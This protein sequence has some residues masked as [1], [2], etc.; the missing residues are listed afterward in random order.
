MMVV[1]MVLAAPLGLPPFYVNLSGQVL[2]YAIL[3]LSLDLLAGVLGLWS[4][5]HAAAFGVAAYTAAFLAERLGVSWG[6][7]LISGLGVAAAL[8]CVGGLVVMRVRGLY[9]MMLTLG[10]AQVLWALAENWTGLTGG[11]DGIPG[12]GRPSPFITTNSFYV[13]L[14]ACFALNLLVLWAIHRS[15]YGLILR[16][17]RDNALRMEALGVATFRARL[18]AYVLASTIGGFA[19]VLF[20]WQQGLVSPGVLSVDTSAETLLMVI[21]G[22]A[23]TLGGPILGAVIVV[24]LETLV[25]TITARWMTAL[26]VCYILTVLGAPQGLYPVL[27]PKVARVFATWGRWF[28][29]IGDGKRARVEGDS[30]SL[31]RATHPEGH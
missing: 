5:G 10:I 30:P 28:G 3:A 22:G 4:L 1:G 2:I 7:Q 11:A 19:G 6:I 14:A 15:N 20:A 9:F 25:S 31:R 21:L 8:G 26:G 29:G 23:G 24:L 17:I 18:G 16:G 27:M 13:F 12:I